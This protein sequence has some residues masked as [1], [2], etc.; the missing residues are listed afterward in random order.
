MKAILRN[1]LIAIALSSLTVVGGVFA[2]TSVQAQEE[3]SESSAE[4]SIS[5]SG[6]NVVQKLAKTGQ[7][8]TLI[9]AVTQAGL[10]DTLATTQG[11][12]VFAPTDAA[13]AKIPAA[14]LQALI[15]DREKLKSVLTYH[16]SPRRLRENQLAQRGNAPTLYGANITVTG[17]PE[18]LVLNGNVSLTLGDI[19]ATNGIIHSID[20]V[21][22][23]PALPKDVV[24]TA[25]AAGSFNTLVAAVQAAGL[26]QTL[27]NTQNITV[28]APTDAAFAKI[29]KAT[30]DAILAD[31]ALLTKIL[32]YHVSGRTISAEQLFN[33]RAG[34]IRTLEG[35]RIRFTARDGKVVLND[36]VMVTATDIKASNGII[37]VIDAVLI[38]PSI[39]N[40]PTTTTAAPTTTVPATTTTTPAALKDV[41]D[42]AIAAGSFGTLVTAV[43]AAGLEQTLRT[44]KNITV[45][46]PTNAAFAKIPKATLDAI[47]AD[48][49]L[50][51]KILTYHVS[52]RTISAEQLFNA[53]VGTID[54]LQGERVRFTAKDGKVL[55][56]DT[57]M[58]TATDIKASN[59]IIHVLDAVLIPPSIA[60][61]P[62]T[63]TVAPIPT[64]VP[65][66]TPP[67]T[68][69]VTTVAP[70]TV[71]PIPTTTKP[72]VPVGAKD[73][74]DTAIGAGG[75]TTLVA[76]VQAAGLESTLRTAKG[77]TVFAP[78]DAAFA[79]LGD[80]T[81]KA[82]LADPKALGTI[83]KYHVLPITLTSKQIVDQHFGSVKTLQGQSIF[84]YVRNGAIILNNQVAV[85]VRDIPASNGIIHVIDT[86]LTVPGAQ[87]TSSASSGSA[88]SLATS[89][90]TSNSASAAVSGTVTGNGFAS[91]T[92]SSSSTGAAA[93]AGGTPKP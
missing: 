80:A 77:I 21:L 84:Y 47:L 41:V 85:T 10:A 82:L 56:N 58:V 43:Q 37:H 16:V 33:A 65:P 23:P 64:T 63:T 32:T 52:G 87:A 49:A 34:T 35:E 27:R 18:D 78:T 22:T 88:S 48:K 36:T 89:S 62:T 75:F 39:A 60:N 45:F 15:A 74:V 91:A 19:R 66:T 20:T 17:T 1:K 25:I 8:S 54:T 83:L 12:T 38:P 70:T 69:P 28:F 81:I 7:Y 90:S 42:T 46:A 68:L 59:G 67:T 31:K 40:A 26:E 71:A 30:L 72:I 5:Q 73:I 93:S 57:V 13:F 29:P 55:L 61:P 76:A 51:T 14:D 24:A 6:K 50:L 79:K 92:S 53:G 11:I 3:P 9:T 2:A 44:T 86:V 4:L